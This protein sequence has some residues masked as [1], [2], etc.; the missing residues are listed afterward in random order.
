MAKQKQTTKRLN[1]AKVKAIIISQ[2]ENRNKK[3]ITEKRN[4]ERLGIVELSGD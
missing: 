3:K 1:I 4:K 2:I